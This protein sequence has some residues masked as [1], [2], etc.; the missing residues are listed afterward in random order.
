MN[1]RSSLYRP[2]VMAKEPA[3]SMTR[4]ANVLAA[5]KL[6]SE[7]ASFIKNIYRYARVSI[8]PTKAS[9]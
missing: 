4:E 8:G 5:Y 2:T 7:D 6:L 9:G 1:S 3:M